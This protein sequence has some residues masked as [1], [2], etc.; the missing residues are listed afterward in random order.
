M[1]IIYG[2]GEPNPTIVQCIAGIGQNLE[3]T[4]TG[5]TVVAVIIFT[6]LFTFKTAKDIFKALSR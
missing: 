3:A 2:I 6:V 4:I 5:V 1:I